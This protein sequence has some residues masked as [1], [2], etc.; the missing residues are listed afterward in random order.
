MNMS[1]AAR[2]AIKAKLNEYFAPSREVLVIFRWPAT[3][4]ANS[5]EYADVVANEFFDSLARHFSILG[6]HSEL[7]LRL[8]DICGEGI[9]SL[10]Q[11]ALGA[12]QFIMTCPEG[13][14]HKGNII[15]LQTVIEAIN[16]E[17]LDRFG[18]RVISDQDIRGSSVVYT[19]NPIDLEART[20]HELSHRKISVYV[21]SE[22]KKQCGDDRRGGH[23]VPIKL[24]FEVSSRYITPPELRMVVPLIGSTIKDYF[25]VYSVNTS[26]PDGEN[27]NVL[28][29]AV[30]VESPEDPGESPDFEYM[31]LK[32]LGDR[33]RKLNRDLRQ[34]TAFSFI[35]NIAVESRGPKMAFDIV[36]ISDPIM[37][38]HPFLL[39][40]DDEASG[41]R[42]GGIGSTGD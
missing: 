1:I 24:N 14:S 7:R 4:A 36:R 3:K 26:Y 35:D 41:D 19:I 37:E 13:S 21:A 12:W 8:A 38:V 2:A 33:L 28:I 40:D 16:L 27:L 11:D 20:I 25:T 5:Y 17:F 39:A 6:E 18:A 9:H 30:V 31:M 22:L 34:V 10:P 23:V 42:T 29:N 32:K 15:T